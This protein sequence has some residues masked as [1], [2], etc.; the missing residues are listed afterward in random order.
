MDIE[1][2]NSY[3]FHILWSSLSFVFFQ[4]LENVDHS[5]VTDCVKT[6]SSHCS[7]TKSTIKRVCSL[8]RFI[9]AHLW[10]C[11]VLW[12]FKYW[13]LN[14]LSNLCYHQI[15][16]VKEIPF[17]DFYFARKSSMSSGVVSYVLKKKNWRRALSFIQHWFIIFYNFNVFCILY[18]LCLCLSFDFIFGLLCERLISFIYL[19]LFILTYYIIFFL[20]H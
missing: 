7:L 12:S 13:I 14:F 1:I 5:Q 20:V 2:W 9:R 8:W 16:Y 3:N 19:L 15:F 18:F 10:N 17:D 11:L 6:G 4:P